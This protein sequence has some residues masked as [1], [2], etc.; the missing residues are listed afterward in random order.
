MFQ[1]VHV[2][3]GGAGFSESV[4]VHDHRLQL[5]L[6]HVPGPRRAPR[7][8]S[9][10]QSDRVWDVWWVVG[11]RFGSGSSDGGGDVLVKSALSGLVMYCYFGA[12]M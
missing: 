6:L 12:V 1:N 3:G 9:R 4:P 11:A 7:T 5:L 2:P 8:V 10:S